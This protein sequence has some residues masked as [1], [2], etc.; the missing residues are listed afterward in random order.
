MKERGGE[1]GQGDNRIDQAKLTMELRG[2]EWFRSHASGP[3][4]HETWNDS[5]RS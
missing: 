2:W 3:S 5:A 1:G 4:C